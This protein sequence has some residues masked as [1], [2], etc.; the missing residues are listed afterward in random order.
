[1]ITLVVA[2][3]LEDGYNSPMPNSDSQQD[4]LRVIE[5][6]DSLPLQKRLE[7]FTGLSAEAREE[8]VRVVANPGEIIRKIAPEEMYLT[9]KEAGEQNAP[10][11]I[12]L[13]TGRQLIYVLDIELWKKD[14]FNAEAA[15]RW[16][17]VLAESGEEKILQF[18]Q[19][20]DPELVLSAIKPFVK[21]A[22]RNPDQDL[23]EQQDSL[24]QFTLDD[25]FYVEFR[26]PYLEETLKSIL[27]IIFRWNS[28]FYFGLME[29]LSSGQNLEDEEMALKWRKAR[30]ADKGF[31]EF[32]EA[33]QIYSYL[34]RDSLSGPLAEP[35]EEV[36]D[37]TREP[38]STLAY[39]LKVIRPESLFKQCLD[40]LSNPEEKDRIAEQ[41][42]HTAN[43][44]IIADGRD[45]GS[46]EDLYGSLRKVGGYINIAL[47]EMCGANVVEAT[48]IVRSNHMEFLFRR[49]FSLI[50]DL[51]KEAQKLIRDYE[52]GV[53]NLGHPLAGIV[54]GLLQRRPLYAGQFVSNDTSRDFENLS[55]IE[56]IRRMLDQ[57]AIE[58]RWEPI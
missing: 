58:D 50:L 31:P 13:T 54:D 22:L 26:V 27:D 30:L 51:R 34:R 44:V 17:E 23:L 8:L 11:L 33:L 9:I 55:E 52:G 5:R 24:P 16:L 39:P 18:I 15:A 45:P 2:F 41:L 49:G 4:A 48:G 10:A 56:Q 1:M 57:S 37:P 20:A 47:E 38:R 46:R 14:M 6:F 32:D 36:F 19:V 42:A 25:T 21:V 7:I 29:H 43:K 35:L 53:E 28:H 3:P 12:S 40:E